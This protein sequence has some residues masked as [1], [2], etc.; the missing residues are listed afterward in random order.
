MSYFHIY[1]R[2]RFK[3]ISAFLLDE[4]YIIFF[5]FKQMAYLKFV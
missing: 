4:D 1:L 3:I 2:T 5:T